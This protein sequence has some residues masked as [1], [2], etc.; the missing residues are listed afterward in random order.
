MMKNR[1]DAINELLVTMSLFAK[2][3]KRASSYGTYARL[4]TEHLLK[5][6]LLKEC[7]LTELLIKQC[8]LKEHL[9]CKGQFCMA[10]LPSMA[11]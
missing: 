2:C 11:R 9:R 8:L 1:H 3:R 10:P 6:H 5:K 4:L 7:L